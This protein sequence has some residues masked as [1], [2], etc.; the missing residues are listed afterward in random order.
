M[1]V[2]TIRS[3][4]DD[5]YAKLKASAES[6]RRSLNS[7]AIVTL[8]AMLLPVQLNPSDR[9]IRARELR[10]GERKVRQRDDIWK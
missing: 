3:V 9:L 2:L 1:P 10:R 8:E 7:E 5:L 4:P 6:S